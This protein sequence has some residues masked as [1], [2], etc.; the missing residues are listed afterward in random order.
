MSKN[1]I[2]IVEPTIKL[3]EGMLKQSKC[4]NYLTNHKRGGGGASMQ[5][6]LDPIVLFYDLVS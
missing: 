6:K 5:K 3:G 1:N 2:I 4:S